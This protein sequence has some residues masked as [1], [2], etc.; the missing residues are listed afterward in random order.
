MTIPVKLTD[1][2]HGLIEAL[3]SQKG[4]RAEAGST[5]AETGLPHRR[6][7]SWKWSDLKRHLPKSYKTPGKSPAPKAPGLFSDLD[8]VE[9]VFVDGHLVSWP[10]RDTVAQAIVHFHGEPSAPMMANRNHVSLTGAALTPPDDLIVLTIDEVVDRPIWVRFLHAEGDVSRFSRLGIKLAPGA[11]AN[12][13]VS[14][15]GQQSGFEQTLTEAFIDLEAE[16]N[17]TVIQ[18]N[19]PDSVLVSQTEAH[20]S[21]EARFNQTTLG[22][23]GKLVRLET[24]VEHPGEGTSVDMNA[25]YL[26][27]KG[28]HFDS[29][30]DVHHTGE[31][32]LTRQLTKGAVAEKATG[33][34]QGK[35]HVERA[36]QKTDAEM[37]HRG[38]HLSDGGT[39]NAKP[40]LEIY[41]DDVVCAHGNAIGAIDEDALF[42]MRQRGLSDTRAR[43]L[44]TESFLSEPLETIGHD[45]IREHLIKTLKSRLDSTS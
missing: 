45:V 37:Q 11:S 22:F 28:R 26:L 19:G 41:A 27:D 32:G 25:A 3:S 44:L 1:F 5:L 16:L 14:H 40:E 42:Y 30:S 10:E 18:D 24:H 33:V 43:A 7:E 15:E 29:T 36:A 20:L 35:F 23:G 12:V 31:G 13:I 4:W 38:L 8:A 17:L 39:I 21:P 34:F 2:E 9:I 6:V